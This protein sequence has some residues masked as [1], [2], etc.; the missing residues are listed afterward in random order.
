MKQTTAVPFFVALL[1]G[2]ESAWAGTKLAD[3]PPEFYRFSYQ[4]ANNGRI[5]ENSVCKKY[6]GLDWKGCRRYAQWHFAVQC[7]DLGYDIKHQTGSVRQ[8][9]KKEKEFFC[10]AKRRVTPLR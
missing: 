4:T 10:D 5:V 1:L 3:D 2:L 6:S 7:W 8:K 9:M